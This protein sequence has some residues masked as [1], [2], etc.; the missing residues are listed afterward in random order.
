MRLAIT[1]FR[2]KVARRFTRVAQQPSRGTAGH[3]A[4]IRLT[5]L[6]AIITRLRKPVAITATTRMIHARISNV[7]RRHVLQH[8]KQRGTAQQRVIQHRVVLAKHVPT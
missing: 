8:Q 4:K 2:Q 7:V 1:T 3:I 6:P 5:V